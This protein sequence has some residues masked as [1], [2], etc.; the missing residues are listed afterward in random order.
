[1][2]ATQNGIPLISAFF[3]LITGS[4]YLFGPLKCIKLKR[5]EN[6]ALVEVELQTKRFGTIDLAD[7]SFS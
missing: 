1:M 4:F 3:L 7:S 2:Y 6:T 5:G